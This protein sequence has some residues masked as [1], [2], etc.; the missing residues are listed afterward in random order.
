MRKEEVFARYGGEE[1]V[2][3]PRDG[4]RQGRIF[5]ARILKLVSGTALEWEARSLQMTVSLAFASTSTV[6]RHGERTVRARRLSDVP[7]KRGGRNRFCH[8]G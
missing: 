4:S 8:D 5:A 6:V 7:A 3:S 1:F 2:V